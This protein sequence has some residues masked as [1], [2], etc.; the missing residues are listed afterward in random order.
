MATKTAKEKRRENILQ[1][2]KKVR[3]MS[4]P[5]TGLEMY[6]DQGKEH[7]TYMGWENSI[8]EFTVPRDKRTGNLVRILDDEEQKYFEEELG[9]NLSFSD[10]KS[11]LTTLSVNVKIDKSF[12]E[13]GIEF[14][15][16]IPEHVLKYKIVKSNRDVAPT[17]EDR[18]SKDRYRWMLVEGDE[19][20][21][22]KIKKATK[23]MRAY[24]Y[25]AEIEG[26]ND[27]MNLILNL[28]AYET[29]APHPSEKADK[30]TYLGSLNSI[31]ESDID[32]FLDIAE[33]ENK[34]LKLIITKALVKNIITFNPDQ[35]SYA[36]K[37]D[38]DDVI[39]VGRTFSSIVSFFADERN[40]ANKQILIARVAK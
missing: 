11:H 19:Q 35:R 27:E 14:D 2:G 39:P 4:V 23:A 24:K 36:F 29:G 18:F 10:P 21:K 8:R 34:D 13:R 7:V 3:L 40:S 38:N 28:Y 25:L 31:I 15:L 26:D 20:D 33:D 9:Y 16:G 22:T 6:S 12:K 1:P 30:D 17:F 37:N 5:R 32:R